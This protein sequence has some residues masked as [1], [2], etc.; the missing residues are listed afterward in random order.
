MAT[1]INLLPWRA[2]L[3]EQRKREFGGMLVLAL[4][5]GAGVWFGVHTHLNGQIAHQENRNE[6]LRDEIAQLDKQI[7]KIKDLEKTK[8]QLLARMQ[9]IQ[10]LQQ[11]RPQIVHVFE[12]LVRTVPDG[13][14]LTKV[15]ESGDKLSIDG[16][17]ESNGRIS[18]YMESLEASAWLKNPNLQIIEVKEQG[19]SRVSRFSM[20]V[21]E[22]TPGAEEDEKEGS[23]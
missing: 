13:L 18:N 19:S 1:K 20:T 22:T 16:M 14:Y 11:G 10:E 2:E 9:V 4:V 23:S 6:F 15:A 12:Q 8:Q 21:Q 17:A 3:R 7:L 5:A